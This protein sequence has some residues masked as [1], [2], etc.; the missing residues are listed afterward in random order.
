VHFSG[1]S[2]ASRGSLPH[3][4]SQAAT[5]VV[6]AELPGGGD[7][8]CG[9]S[10]VF[11]VL[12]QTGVR[13]PPGVRT[14]ALCRCVRSGGSTVVTVEKHE[15]PRMEKGGCVITGSC[16]LSHSFEYLRKCVIPVS[17]VAAMRLRLEELL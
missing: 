15:A 9:A 10:G 2:S 1:S 3:D 5:L 6:S 17:Q 4:V 16:I 12:G 13:L 8:H 11:V 7:A 14:T